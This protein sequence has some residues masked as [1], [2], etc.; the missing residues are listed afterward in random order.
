MDHECIDTWEP[1]HKYL[2]WCPVCKKAPSAAEIIRALAVVR[3]VENRAEYDSNSN[4]INWC[5]HTL[6]ASDD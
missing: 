6:E 5:A 4:P 1:F 2:V 3:D